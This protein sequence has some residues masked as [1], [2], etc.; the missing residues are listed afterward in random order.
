MTIAKRLIILLAVPLVALLGLGL[1]TR[2]QL[3]MVEDKSQFVAKIQ[4]PSLATLGNL[5]R[6]FQELRVNV[7][8]CLLATDQ[9]EQGKARAAFEATEAELTRL[10]REYNDACISDEKDRRLLSDF[11]GAYRDWL[12]GA[13]QAAKLAAEGRRDP[14]GFNAPPRSVPRPATASLPG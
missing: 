4:I 1:F 2:L 9:Q 3:S 13:R 12:V 7:R 10:L 5:S 11:Q 8:N 6:N 14:C